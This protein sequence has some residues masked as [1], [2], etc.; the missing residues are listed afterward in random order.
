MK[1]IDFDNGNITSNILQS[2]GPM[3]VAQFLNLLYNIVDRIYIARIPIVGTAALGAVGLVFPIIVII[4]AFTNWFGVGGSPVFSIAR[5]RGDKKAAGM[6]LNTS[7][8]MLIFTAAVLMIIGYSFGQPI[9]RLFGASDDS[10][11]YAYP[12]LMI[13]LTG[14]F[15][16]MTATGLNPFITAQGYATTGMRSV[17]IGAVANLV[18]DPLFIFTFGLGIRGAAIATV[19][20]QGLSAV[21]V[22]YFLR[23]KAEYRV[24]FLRLS[25]LK[26]A[27]HYAG[28]IASLGIASFIMQITNSLCTIACN[29]VLSITGGDIYISVMTIIS[30]ARQIVELPIYA[31]ADGSSPIIS[32][33]YGATKPDRVFKAGLT[34]IVLCVIYTIPMWIFIL[35]APQVL[36][37][38]FSSDTSLLKDTIPSMRIYFA[39]FGFMLPQYAGQTVFRALGK[40][41]QS[42]F[43][44]LLRKVVIV[45]PLTYILP[46]AFGMGTNGVFMAEPISNVLGGTACF[47]TMLLTVLPELKRMEKEEHL[48]RKKVLW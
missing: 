28:E 32:Y 26:E 17:I 2:A 3:L 46:L 15:F 16:S 29:N 31:I 33:N 41:K 8:C 36:I 1:R 37:A 7:F 34:M 44:S 38:I 5:G 25:Q 22:F 35:A 13:Y 12:Y 42:V 9:L 39:A 23:K 20:S 14:T 18:L 10:M 30:S 48:S 19:I 45:V 24:Q 43:F 47:T 6:I 40:K 27:L 21:Y 4:T 11:V